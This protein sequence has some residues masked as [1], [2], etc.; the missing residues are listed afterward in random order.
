MAAPGTHALTISTPAVQV[1]L[2][3][4]RTG[5]V[6]FTVT[7]VAGV[8]V[9]AQAVIRPLEDPPADWFKI[10]DK[11]PRVFAPGAVQQLVVEVD[12]PLGTTAGVYPFRLDLTGVAPTQFVEEGPACSVEVPASTTGLTEP[13][14]YVA[15]LTGAALGGVLWLAVILGIVI[16][17]KSR[18]DCSGSL[19]DCLGD[20]FGLIILLVLLF[21]V[22]L[23]LMFVGAA[24]G[25]WLALRSKHYLGAKLTAVFFAVLMVP[26]AIAM[27]AALS[28]LGVHDTLFVVLSPLVFLVVPAVVARASVLLIKTHRV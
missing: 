24:V 10:G 12:P 15:T 14:G 8:E 26:W 22:G 13:R 16:F 21:L 3:P 5:E 27:F 1:P 28:A 4:N 11:A 6:P 25:I 17:G 2:P 19:G 20:I 23:A 9:S 18:A 7:N